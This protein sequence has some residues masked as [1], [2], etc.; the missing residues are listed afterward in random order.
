MR[1]DHMTIPTTSTLAD[2]AAAVRLDTSM[3]KRRRDGIARSLADIARLLGR[4]P[5]EL[6]GNPRLL[7]K[8][9]E[10]LVLRSANG[11]AAR[12]RL[13]PDLLAAVERWGLSEAPGRYAAPLIAEWRRTAA[14]LAD[15]RTR[16]TLSRIALSSGMRRKAAS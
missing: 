15:E 8:R 14:R 12:D 2:L 10:L 6:P 11:M 9:A 13:R 3:W 4:K 1:L 7:L 16:L 5:T